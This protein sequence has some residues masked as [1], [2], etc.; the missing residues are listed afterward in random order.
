MPQESEALIS[1]IPHAATLHVLTESRPWLADSVQQFGSGP[2]VQKSVF[3]LAVGPQ[4]L[5]CGAAQMGT[6][7]HSLSVHVCVRACACACEVFV[8]A[9]AFVCSNGWFLDSF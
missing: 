1:K 5:Q 9:C 7:V 2:I 4:D 6:T 8:C 3:Q